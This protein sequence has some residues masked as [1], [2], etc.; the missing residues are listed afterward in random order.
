MGSIYVKHAMSH[1]Y[2][3]RGRLL[4]KSL[5]YVYRVK[6]S[7]IGHHQFSDALPRLPLSSFVSWYN[8]TIVQR[9]KLRCTDL[10]NYWNCT[11]Q[12]KINF[13]TV[14]HM[15]IRRRESTSGRPLK[16][17]LFNFA[18]HG[19]VPGHEAQMQTLLEPRPARVYVAR[20]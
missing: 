14:R 10:E 9:N 15:Y 3:G 17:Q 18:T 13:R 19:I 1:S 12:N 6:P 7:M 11:R 16:A 4:R 5:K 2:H 20:R 8:Q